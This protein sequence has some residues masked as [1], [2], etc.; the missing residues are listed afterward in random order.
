MFICDFFVICVINEFEILAV[1][2][3]RL[4]L[5]E[6]IQ[7]GCCES[8]LILL[9]VLSFSPLVFSLTTFIWHLCRYKQI[10]VDESAHSNLAGLGST[11]AIE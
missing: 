7:F 9:K 1:N 10:N 3:W 6:V 4:E 8:C 5:W 11:H 2:K